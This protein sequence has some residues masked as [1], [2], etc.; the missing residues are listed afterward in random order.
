MRKATCT[1]HNTPPA[2]NEKDCFADLGCRPSHW[3][4]VPDQ[5]PAVDQ[6]ASICQRIVSRFLFL[7]SSTFP[8]LTRCYIGPSI[9]PLPERNHRKTD[10]QEWSCVGV[11]RIVRVVHVS[12]VRSPLTSRHFLHF[13]SVLGAHARLPT[14]CGLPYP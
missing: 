4:P 5:F 13:P 12:V 7:A 3:T 9:S 11:V 6:F 14:E 8:H 1:F 10:C 2:T